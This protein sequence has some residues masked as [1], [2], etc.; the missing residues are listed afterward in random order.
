MQHLC[1]EYT[2]PRHEKGT[3]VRGWI[4]KDTRIGPVVNIQ[5]CYHDVRYSVEVQIP[6]LFEDNTASWVGIVNGVDKYETES[7]LTKKEEDVASGKPS[8]KARPRQKPTVTLTSVSILVLERKWIDI[9]TQRSHDHECYEV[10]KAIT[11]LLRHDQSVPR[12]SDGA[13]HCSDI[14]E[15]RRK[16]FDGVSQW[17]LEDWI[18]TLAKGGG[19][20][21]RVQYCVNPNSSNQFLHLRAIQGHSGHNGI[22]PALQDNELLPKELTEYVYHVGNASEVNSF[23]RNGLIP[24]GR[25]LERGRQAVFFTT[26]NPMDDVFGMGET[27]RDLT[28]ARIAPYKNTWKRLQILYF[29]AI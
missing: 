24:G 4:R 17:L 3:R 28:K 22:D 20:K 6:S 10:S 27:P 16:K 5:V 15:C 13:I 29:G 8:A 12:G 7:M 26:A 23:I 19:A 21:K 18:S 25:S 14:M 2:M 9:E 1:R 11:R